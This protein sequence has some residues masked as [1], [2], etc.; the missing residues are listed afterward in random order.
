MTES[1]LARAERVWRESRAAIESGSLDAIR[2]AAAR[3]QQ[4]ANDPE[5]SDRSRPHI[6]YDAGAAWARLLDTDSDA[7]ER[8][9]DCE[10]RS[11]QMFK[12]L[13]VG[14][15]V[16]AA[17]G[18]VHTLGG[19]TFIFTR[20]AG[21][22]GARALDS[23]W[24]EVDVARDLLAGTPQW[25]RIGTAYSNLG[26][27]LMTSYI[28]QGADSG[29]ASM[30][31]R[32]VGAFDTAIEMFESVAE[33]GPEHDQLAARINRCLCM[34]FAVTG[35]DEVSRLT[36][37]CLETYEWLVSV[38][39]VD[40]AYVDTG[41]GAGCMVLL[42]MQ[43]AL[44]AFLERGVGD[45]RLAIARTAG[46]RVLRLAYPELWFPMEG[47]FVDPCRASG[48]GITPIEF[49]VSTEVAFLEK[50]FVEADQEQALSATAETWPVPMPFAVVSAMDRL[51]RD[52]PWIQQF[53]AWLQGRI[54]R[55]ETG[56]L[57]ST[58][59]LAERY[60]KFVSWWCER[61]EAPIA[62]ME[63]LRQA[64]IADSEAS[65]DDRLHRVSLLAG[66][67]ASSAWRWRA[68]EVDELL[69][70]ICAWAEDEASKE[71]NLRWAQAKLRLLW[72]LVQMRPEACG[73]L[74]REAR[75]IRAMLRAAGPPEADA[76][77]VYKE[78]AI[79]EA[80]ALQVM[81]REDGEQAL[82]AAA[83]S[84][85][86]E[87]G[88]DLA[89]W[90]VEPDVAERL[91]T[92][93]TEEIVL[94][95]G[96]LEEAVASFRRSAADGSPAERFLAW[97]L[98]LL[99]A[100]RGCDLDEE[101]VASAR[102]AMR[103]VLD[104][105]SLRPVPPELPGAF[106]ALAKH[107]QLSLSMQDG[108]A[109]IDLGLRLAQEDDATDL[110]Q[111]LRLPVVVE[112]YERCAQDRLQRVRA[113][114]RIAQFV[115][116]SRQNLEGIDPSICSAFL[117][118]Q[119]LDA[120]PARGASFT[121]RRSRITVAIAA[122][123]AACAGGDAAHM[124]VSLW[125]V[126]DHARPYGPQLAPP[127]YGALDEF[128]ASLPAVDLPDLTR[129]AIEADIAMFSGK[130]VESSDVE[131]ASQL[132]SQAT[133]IWR[134]SRFNAI[135]V[136]GD[137]E[138]AEVW[139][140]VDEFVA[141]V[142]A[143]GE[144]DEDRAAWILNAAH[145]A[146]MLSRRGVQIDTSVVGRLADAALAAARSPRVPQT[147]VG[148]PLLELAILFGVLVSDERLARSALASYRAAVNQRILM[149]PDFA[150]ALD[151][152]QTLGAI[153]DATTE[154]LKRK[155]GIALEIAESGRAK[156]LTAMAAGLLPDL[157]DRRD[158]SVPV[159]PTV[160]G[161]G[162]LV[163]R[164]F[165]SPGADPF[166]AVTEL[167][168]KTSWA[169]AVASLVVPWRTLSHAEELDR[170]GG[171]WNPRVAQELRSSALA[172]PDVEELLDLSEEGR[173]LT[174][175][176][177]DL[178][179]PYVAMLLADGTLLLGD[180]DVEQ[181][182]DFTDLGPVTREELW[183]RVPEATRRA[184]VL[185]ALNG[186]RLPDGARTVVID[187]AV[188]PR[189]A[190]DVANGISLASNEKRIP[191][192]ASSARLLQ[193][194]K[195]VERP[196]PA[197]EVTVFA[198]PTGDLPGSL[199][200]ASAWAARKDIAPRLLMQGQATVEAFLAALCDSRLVVLSTHGRANQ[201][202]GAALRLADGEVSIEHLLRLDAAIAAERVILSCC[203]GGAHS[204]WISRREALGVV[205]CL[206]ALGVGEVIAPVDAVDD[207]ATGIF[208]AGLARAYRPTA[209]VGE[210]L[211]QARLDLDRIS[212]ELRRNEGSE[213]IRAGVASGAVSAVDAA[214]LDDAEAGLRR[215]TTAD[216]VRVSAG[217][218]VFGT[219]SS[220]EAGDLP[221]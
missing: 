48:R 15:D 42:A 157:G 150:A 69:R 196:E 198:N 98:L 9:L 35:E 45:H 171:G 148:L 75:A 154:A 3:L 175:A 133:F 95:Q 217:F 13:F 97:R 117:T 211:R 41:L 140:E 27:G 68:A 60:G 166:G 53:V 88:E 134:A 101:A 14:G 199:L 119:A 151:S 221:S 23:A 113:A 79:G 160:E 180:G 135:D 120:E 164:M 215:T 125:A 178:D 96:S 188:D 165:A 8:A 126:A 77:S 109:L 192:I 57:S 115:F 55:A 206:L 107:P 93:A 29:D 145:A 2:L 72:R 64:F 67:I 172:D 155:L 163:D 182:P 62:E 111:L 202:T 216:V 214:Q 87:I 5:I 38:G 218:G 21:V 56:Q 74:H 52:E 190:I 66:A 208:G 156:L 91:L 18:W 124:A 207:L 123:V 116:S 46:S 17:D 201:R 161:F 99:I 213:W 20:A 212:P 187:C 184:L 105:A 194:H 16:S 103:L 104:E 10:I 39:R 149:A 153:D 102:D 193:M 44:N 139:K 7:P 81:T 189:V 25:P 36:E 73:R 143:S 210:T 128:V 32:A 86:G 94:A 197:K 220:S 159:V 167:L 84:L 28:E 82:T 78:A 195:P 31:D 83:D 185:H 209:G 179:D 144:E 24:L 205:S 11:A 118:Q 108:L 204:T 26:A 177:G 176:L 131:Q 122:L 65:P 137:F 106:I 100:E 142:Q 4:L 51:G 129:M 30:R 85:R 12:D 158:R 43:R 76:L 92:F 169:D 63:A 40:E 49:I 191:P 47:P 6:L 50:V 183:Q 173:V 80:Y 219:G 127:L 121:D 71:R 114:E 162:D 70:L 186:H 168:R 58:E 136:D 203:W 200:E 54:E 19:L 37:C 89:G 130:P 112:R 181:P 1:A 174:W 146:L 152:V 61:P 22:L 34:S 170:L 90:G 33:M 59:Q 147:A 141:D 138:D 110:N 132:G